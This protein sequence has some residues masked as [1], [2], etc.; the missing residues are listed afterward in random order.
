MSRLVKGAGADLA[1]DPRRVVPAA[2]ADAHEQAAR[3]LAGAEEQAERRRAEADRALDAERDRVLAD[4]RARGEAEA[5]ALLVAAQAERTERLDE[6][7]QELPRLIREIARRVLGRELAQSPAAVVDVVLEALRPLRHRRQITLRLAPGDLP[8]LEAAEPR[9]QQ[10]VG[11]ARLEL[12]ADTSVEPGG[13]VVQTEVGRVDARLST[14][15]ERLVAA[16]MGTQP[17]SE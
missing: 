1:G 16:V 9:L 11:A 6:V 4:A 7:E 15:L 14:Q 8:A 12:I 13:C 2:L 3:L 17:E 5:A 10:L